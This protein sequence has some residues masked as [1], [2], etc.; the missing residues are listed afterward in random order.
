MN[1]SS[2]KLA[3]LSFL[4]L[5]ATA[6]TAGFVIYKQEQAGEEVR[7]KLVDL[8]IWSDL[9]H[10]EDSLVS[11]TINELGS[12][13]RL[14]ALVLLSESDTIEFLGNVESIA[15]A[16][17]VSVTTIELKEE[18]IT[19]PH[20]NELLATFSLRGDEE[21]V[22]RVL[23]LMELLPYRSTINSLMLN[24]AAGVTS[25]TVVLRVSTIKK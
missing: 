23:K 18:K 22:E 11:E 2:F 19:D 8:K 10:A 12:R 9:S 7:S 13:S 14:R 16:R 20:F 17:G 3:L 4:I 25:A 21:E 24:R 5:V 6:A 1:N 15:E